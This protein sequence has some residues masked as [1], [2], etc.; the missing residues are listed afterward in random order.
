MMWMCVCR[1]VIREG[2]VEEVSSAREREYR[3]KG[4]RKRARAV[5]DGGGRGRAPL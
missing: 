2:E 1:E 3:K 4:R 5:V